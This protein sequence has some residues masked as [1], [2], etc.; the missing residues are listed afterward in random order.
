MSIYSRCTL[1]LS[2]PSPFFT[3]PIALDLTSFGFDGKLR[4]LPPDL[5]SSR[6]ARF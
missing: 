6:F 3:S 1:S 4:V 5:T 2:L